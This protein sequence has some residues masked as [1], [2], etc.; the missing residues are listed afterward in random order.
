[1]SEVLQQTAQQQLVGEKKL[2][3]DAPFSRVS[4][5][6]A[7]DAVTAPESYAYSE[8]DPLVARHMD[9][10]PLDEQR[11]RTSVLYL[12]QDGHDVI[13]TSAGSYSEYLKRQV[14]DTPSLDAAFELYY[15]H[16]TDP[17][18]AIDLLTFIA[19]SY[20]NEIHQNPD[21]HS[22]I[23]ELAEQNARDAEKVAL[24]EDEHT[25][26][27][28]GLMSLVAVADIIAED[29]KA[30][31]DILQ[32]LDKMVQTNHDTHVLANG[33][34]A[35]DPLLT[36]AISDAISDR[37][38]ISPDA[39]ITLSELVDQHVELKKFDAMEQDLMDEI[40]AKQAALTELR[41]QRNEA[42]SNL[43]QEVRI[44]SK[45]R[46]GIRGLLAGLIKVSL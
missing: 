34:S 1:M 28:A 30:E 26:P 38:Q 21:T 6:P 15:K 16:N 46:T 17:I 14:Q 24:G 43:Q 20:A 44:A 2:G 5:E 41:N 8:V 42:S 9:E 25:R 29:P 36:E 10:L 18:N 22:K 7:V 40:A 37:M 4:I 12:D 35:A 33:Q 3:T 45:R 32:R 19:E 11:R 31:A 39:G 13:D 27:E 23:K